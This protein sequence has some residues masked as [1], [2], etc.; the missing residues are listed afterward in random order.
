M[1]APLNIRFGITTG[2]VTVGNIGD[3][4]FSDYTIIGDSVNLA[5]RLEGVNKVYH[6]NI[7]LSEETA[8]RVSDHFILRKLDMISVKGKTQATTIYELMDF[9][10]SGDTNFYERLKTNHERA[11]F[12]YFRQ[13]WDIARMYFSENFQLHDRTAT[14]FLERIRLFEQNPLPS[15]WDGVYRLQDK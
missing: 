3:A 12:A 5:S 8:R 4:N 7:I 13:D 11:L 9:A 15:H 1:G 14:I 10:H 6:T 2:K